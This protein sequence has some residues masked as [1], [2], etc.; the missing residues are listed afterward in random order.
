MKPVQVAAQV[1][2]PDREP[3][4][5]DVKSW[6]ELFKATLSGAKTHDMRRANDRDYRVGDFLLLRE[7]D[8]SEQRYTGRQ[9]R[10][11]I[12]YVTSADFPCA[13]SGAGLHPDYCILSLSPDG[14]DPD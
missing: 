6:P 11:R 5:H 10:M 3:I 2:R 4:Q 13:L 8:P 1:L 7:F 9:L 14:V 12:T